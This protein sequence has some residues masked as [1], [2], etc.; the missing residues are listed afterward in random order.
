M[1]KLLAQYR[2]TYPVALI[3][4]FLPVLAFA[5]HPELQDKNL[6]K[7][8]IVGSELDYFPFAMKNKKG[9]A[10]GFSVELFKA[11]AQVMGFNV[12]FRL[13]PWNEV[14]R[15]LE[16][17]EI[18]ALP[19]VSY[20]EEREKVFDFTTPH[21]VSYATI[22]VRKGEETIHSEEELQGKKIIVMQGDA[23]H[24]YLL[25]HQI[26]QHIH[27]V[28][29][30]SDALRLLASGQEDFALVPRLVGL[31]TAKELNLSNI[32]MTGPKIKVYGRG[33]GFAVKEGNAVLLAHL[34]QGLSIIKASGQYDEIYDIW[35]G[36]VDPRGI[37][38][39]TLYQYAT[40]VLSVFLVILTIAFLGL[41]SFRREIKRRKQAN[42]EIKSI[43]DFYETILES[44]ITGVWVSDKDDVINFA[45]KGMGHLAGL[46]PQQII[47][48]RV[49]TGF[50]ES[51]F[52]FFRPHYLQAKETLQSVY[53]EAIPVTTAVGRQSYQSGWLIPITKESHFNGMICSVEEVTERHQIE[54]KLRESENKHRSLFETMTTGVVYHDAIGNIISANP[55]A[56]GI[57]GL[58]L[59]QMQGRTSFD[60]RGKAIHEDGSYFQEETHPAMISLKTGKQIR[61]V[62]MGVFHPI[63]KKYHWININ[64]IPEFNPKEEK[65]FR[66][67]TTFND[68]TERKQ[69]E[70]E[71]LSAKEA[72]ET[73]NQAK[74][75]F[76]ANMSHELRTPLHA[77][78]GFTDLIRRDSTRS[79]SQ[80]E[81]LDIISH[82]GEHLLALINDILEMS[83]IEAGHITFNEESV[84][85][86]RILKE[87]AEMM[88]IRAEHKGLQFILEH[89][90][91]LEH[92]ITTDAGKL[93]QILINF[94]GNAIKFTENGG[95]SLRVHSQK[96]DTDRK[97]LLF[98]EIEDT[99][100]GIIE[101]DL[102]TIFD[103]FIQVGKQRAASEG[104]GLGLPITRH[105]IQML[106]G[107]VE[108][109]SQL[110][111]GSLFK[112]FISV[113]LAKAD[114][115][116]KQ[117]RSP[118][119]VG[120]S[121]KQAVPRILIVEDIRENR[122]L[123]RKT[124]LKV[125]FEIQE[126]VNGQEAITA[127]EQWHPALICM[128]MRM[129]VLDGYEA[130][131][132][133]KNSATGKK[134]MIIA[135]TASI[136]KEKK[137][138]V[139]A[140]GCDDFLRKPY[141]EDELL[142]MIGEHLNLEYLYEDVK[143]EKADS[144][145]VTLDDKSMLTAWLA[146]SD[147]VK[148]EL[149]Q[150]LKELDL[151][152]VDS[153]MAHIA[154]QNT[155]LAKAMQP[156]VDGFQYEQLAKLLTEKNDDEQT[157]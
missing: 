19:L 30:V 110:G 135:L 49:L 3:L 154:E 27:L 44:I 33:Y 152:L 59:A 146:L 25:E 133:I 67:Y 47:G 107:Q 69:F 119:I 71:L 4:F 116:E 88:R 76:L 43:K 92:F 18:D 8:L 132:R 1:K 106:G 85:L 150:A 54:N 156:Y 127:F 157:N 142:A 118:R 128:D 144:V 9:E 86:H 37:S 22:L 31:I 23:T 73:A 39:E 20:S 87:I 72:A 60:P 38:M 102:K 46:A 79:P 42:A 125:G 137:A 99:G 91:T 90:P 101:Q 58:T 28:K 12:K 51:T 84:D 10:D 136:F 120:L 138:K 68:I 29:T 148:N 145:E 89:E 53:Y 153:A 121:P 26:T 77:I 70:R 123:L 100:V 96:Q 126:A 134:T 131:Q 66:V 61:D 103:P 81:N 122:L 32:E 109:T 63:E 35:F 108:V 143:V 114:D 57:L 75:T 56:E 98:F 41:W 115:I 74:S 17:G 15:A 13:G 124:L 117:T 34:N 155:D 7:P 80:L 64:A 149:N 151:D 94:I 6:S 130:T 140:A 48:S 5:A 113:V 45:N 112:F 78:L 83:K 65:P 62:I 105:Y 93:R 40:L 104:T 82:S 21:T 139:M 14:R 24:N 11:V 97:C 129:P 36:I 55:A 52:K 50:P 111:E 95:V 141:R 147:D 16:K 2:F